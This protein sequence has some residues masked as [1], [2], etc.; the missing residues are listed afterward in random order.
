MVIADLNRLD[1]DDNSSE[2]FFVPNVPFK[3]TSKRFLSYDCR[4]VLSPSGYYLEVIDEYIKLSEYPQ[5]YAPDQGNIWIK[6]S[7][8]KRG[9]R[10]VH[11]ISGNS[12]LIG[13]IKEKDDLITYT[14]PEGKVFTITME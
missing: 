10:M 4:V 8:D 13:Y 9:V 2:W 7:V 3:K 6:K 11:E 1:N 5:G 14:N 12:F